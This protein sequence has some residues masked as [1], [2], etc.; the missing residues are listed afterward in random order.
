MKKIILSIL[1]GMG[2]CL[3]AQAATRNWIGNTDTNFGSSLNWSAAIAGNLANFTNAGSAGAN[4]YNNITGLTLT[5]IT[6]ASNTAQSAYTLSGNAITLNGNISASAGNTSA[7]TVNL[8][9]TIASTMTVTTRAGMTLG[10]KISGAGGLTHGT[11]STGG[12]LDYL[13][14]SGANDFTGDVTLGS[15]SGVLQVSSD[16]NLGS[17]TNINMAQNTTLK[18]TASMTTSKGM[19]FIGAGTANQDISVDP[20]TTLTIG[21][22]VRDTAL[23]TYNSGYFGVRKL[24]AGTLVLTNDANTFNDRLQIQAGILSVSSIANIGQASALGKASDAQMGTIA[25]GGG[26]NSAGLTYTGTGNES[27]RVLNLAGTTGG[28][29]LDQS[30]TGLLKFTS[31]LTATG[32]GAKSLTLQGSTAGT[33]ELGGAIVDSTSAT[34]LKKEGTGKWTLSGANTYTGGTIISNGTLA[35]S[36]SGTLGGSANALTVSTNSA[37]VA[38]TLNL[39]GLSQTVGAVTLTG[40]TITNGT[41]TGSS[42]ALVNAGTISANLGGTGVSLLKNGANGNLTLTGTNTFSGDFGWSSSGTSHIYVNSDAAMGAGSNIRMYQN[43]RLHFTEGLNT[44][45]NII[46]GGAT[47]VAQFIIADAGTSTVSGVISDNNPVTGVSRVYFDGVGTTVLNNDANSFGEQT[48][49]RGNLS[50]SSIKNV[51]GGNSALGNVTNVAQGVIAF[52]NA[53]IGGKLIYTG[54]GDTSD[55]VIDLTGTTATT[56]LD[57]SG[58]GLLKFTSALT[59]SVAGTKTLTLQG[60]T[61]GTGE[62]AGAI[63]DSTNGLTLV[64][65]AGTGKWILSGAN[66]YTGSTTVASGQLV[67]NGSLLSTQTTVNAGATLSGT[68]TVQAVTLDAGAILS[69]GNSPGTMTFAGNLILSAGSTNIMQIFVEGFDVL[70]GSTTNTITM[71]GYNLFDFTGNTVAGGTDFKVLDNWGGI[72]TNGATFDVIGLADGQ[73][74]DYSQLVS[75]GLVTVIPEPA[76]IGMLGLGALITLL[77]RRV[78]TV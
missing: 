37:G 45:K 71:A 73:H 39:G 66:T 18:T 38:A 24:G 15:G 57:Q 44:A 29:T 67:V 69:A 22:L 2:M 1:L 63:V 4:L 47:S 7:Q 20:S 27:D 28:A 68:G 31:A 59:V 17:G 58:T 26:A 50:I 77:I 76:T 41:L 62:L 21:G 65:K 30:G 12:T 56:T 60:S 43:N 42:Y 74:L 52:G 10:G 51:N 5:G 54:A 75:N 70:K 48:F 3:S 25:F 46:L 34:T 35:L 23:A 55:R 13:I 40:G 61:A 8:P 14:L 32:N 33:G 16:A 49:V 11:S 36:G 72:S 6:F 53:G 78:R 64:R 19:T 9:M